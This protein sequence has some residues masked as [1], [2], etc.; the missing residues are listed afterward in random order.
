VPLQ[1]FP[2]FYELDI[3][4]KSLINPAFRICRY[5]SDCW[6]LKSQCKAS[7]NCSE[8]KILH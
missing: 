7:K 5:N 8:R 2:R 1:N 4:S 3:G 6:C